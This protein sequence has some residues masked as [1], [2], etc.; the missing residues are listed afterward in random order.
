MAIDTDF[1]DEVFDIKAVND[2]GY[3]KTADSR[4]R[5]ETRIT[6]VTARSGGVVIIGEENGQPTEKQITIDEAV[7]RCRALIAMAKAPHKYP[8]DQK[9]VR[10]LVQDFAAAIELARS[11]LSIA[12]R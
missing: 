3:D 1:G 2:S 9:G 12:L 4:Q 11:Q 6:K 5:P 8:S 7:H 10:K